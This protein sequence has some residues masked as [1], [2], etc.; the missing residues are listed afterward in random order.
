MS[1]I[2]LKTVVGAEI[3]ATGY[4]KSFID[5]LANYHLKELVMGAT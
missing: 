3:V 4:V 5:I 2:N 1:I